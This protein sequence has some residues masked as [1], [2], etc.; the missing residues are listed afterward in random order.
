[1]PNDFIS[2]EIKGIDKLLASVNQFPKEIASGM[3]AA[4][5]EASNVILNEQ[6]LRKYPSMTAANQPPTPYYIRGRGTQTATGNKMN[7]ERFGTQFYVESKHFSTTIGNRA[8][9]AKWV[10]GNEQARAMARIGWR[11][12]WDVAVEKRSEIT[13]IYQAWVNRIIKKV[14]LS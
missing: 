9:Y 13:R 10:S 2:I 7:S 1:M 11:K 3:S 6:G 5:K 14:G 4:G 8:S 12:L